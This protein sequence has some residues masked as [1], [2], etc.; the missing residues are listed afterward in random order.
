AI[1][2]T[3]DETQ[4]DT[5]PPPGDARM[6]YADYN[7]FYNPDSPS[8]T[9]YSLVVEPDDKTQIQKGSDGFAKHD[10]HA[11]PNFKGPLPTAY[12]FQSSDVQAGTVTVS[13]ILSHF[14]ELYAPGTNSPLTGAGDPMGGAHNNIGAIG[15]GPDL[16]PNDQFGSFMPGMG[17]PPPL[18]LPDAGPSNGGTSNG[19]T[20]N[21]GSGKAS[22]DRGGCGCK[23]A[24]SRAHDA[25][26]FTFAF[27]ALSTIWRRRPK[28][29]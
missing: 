15:Q 5:D 3:D 27:L 14:R 6:H 17:G 18:N 23:I 1:S 10:V 21:G 20:S 13:Q 12:P 9:D 8:Q 11:A 28:R 29:N 26:G 16:D 19:G 24:A 22:S 7:L 2:S 4:Y 25:F